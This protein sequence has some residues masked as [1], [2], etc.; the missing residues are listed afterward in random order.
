MMKRKPRKNCKLKHD[1]KKLCCC[2][3]CM[4]NRA[5][6]SLKLQIVFHQS[7]SCVL[8]NLLICI[9]NQLHFISVV[10][11]FFIFIDEKKTGWC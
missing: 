7:A 8:L 4:Y 9:G 11:N 1:I 10:T 3:V 5:F 2:R 6:K